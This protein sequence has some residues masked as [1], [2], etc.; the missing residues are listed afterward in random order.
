M[1]KFETNKILETHDR[2]KDGQLSK[3]EFES[4]RNHIEKKNNF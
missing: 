3:E 1:P 2:N 4:V